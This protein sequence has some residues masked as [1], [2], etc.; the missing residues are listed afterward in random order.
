MIPEHTVV[1]SWEVA[2]ELVT[3]YTLYLYT[4]YVYICIFVYTK[5]KFNH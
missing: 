3:P 1:N 5:Y 4:V 2:C